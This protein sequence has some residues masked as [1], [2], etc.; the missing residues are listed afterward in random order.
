VTDRKSDVVRDAAGLAAAIAALGVSCS[1][2]TRDGLAVVS[3]LPDGVTALQSV[4][5]RGA[6]VSLARRHGFTHVA[7]ELPA[8]G[9]AAARSAD[10]SVSR[11]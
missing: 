1:L 10:A 9:R 6:L 8:E 4:A 2:E 3:P 7:M 5:L 11:G